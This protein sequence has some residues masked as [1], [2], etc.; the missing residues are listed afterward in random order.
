MLE[1]A[2]LSPIVFSQPWN[3]GRHELPEVDNWLAIRALCLPRDP[4]ENPAP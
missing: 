2:G 1:E 4:E 3:R